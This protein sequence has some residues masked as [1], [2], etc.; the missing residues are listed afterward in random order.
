MD[1]NIPTKLSEA[2]NSYR[3]GDDILRCRVPFAYVVNHKLAETTCDECLKRT[4]DSDPKSSSNKF[5][6]CSGIYKFLVI[7]WIKEGN[8][9][10]TTRRKLQLIS[11][12][13]FH[14]GCKYV[15][16]C[17]T[18]CQKAGWTGSSNNFKSGHREECAYLR[19]V[20]PK[21]PPDTVRLIARIILRLRCG[22]GLDV[23][24][25]PDGSR[26]IYIKIV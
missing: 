23:A 17:G 15:H 12:Y 18:A 10:T 8:P 4:S 25:T 2:A 3:L 26:Y 24:E 19:R 14:V 13:I 21:F 16:Y 9:A 22:G 7:F 11:F 5:L 6:R 1:I 20:S